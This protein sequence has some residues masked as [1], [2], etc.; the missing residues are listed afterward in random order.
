MIIEQALDDSRILHY[1]D[2]GMHIRQVETG[3]VY[4]NAVDILPCQYTYDETDEPIVSYADEAIKEI[5]GE[6]DDISPYS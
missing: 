1:S 3:K 5:E 4:E 6:P 2:I